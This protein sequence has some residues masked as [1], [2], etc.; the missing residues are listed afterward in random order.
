MPSATFTH[1]AHT[2]T[3]ADEVWDRLQVVDTWSKIGPIDQVWDPVHHSGRLHSYR[4]STTVGPTSY[5]GTARVVEADKPRLMRL[6]LDAGEMT[7]DL[8]TELHHNGDGTTRITV[9]LAVIS[10]GMLSTLFFPVVAEA[11]GRGLPRQVDDFAAA[12]GG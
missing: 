6:Q 9:T 8:T 4:W 1:T 2:P 12:F 3:Q 10:R 11:I 5:R 7:G